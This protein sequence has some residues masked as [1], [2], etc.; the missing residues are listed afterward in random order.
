MLALHSE[1]GPQPI[2]ICYQ[3]FA[4]LEPY[5]LVR[6]ARTTKALRNL[7]LNPPSAPVW[8]KCRDN[9]PGLPH[10]PKGLSEPRYA[11]LMFE[12]ICHVRGYTCLLYLSLLLR[13][14]HLP[15]FHFTVLNKGC[16]ERR[17]S[18]S[19]PVLS[20]MRLRTVGGTPLQNSRTDMSLTLVSK[21]SI[22]LIGR[23][24]TTL[25]Y[26]RLHHRLLSTQTTVRL[27]IRLYA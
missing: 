23:R 25:A 1:L 9:V 15:I 5:D 12:Q 24:T 21:L 10:C 18:S 13:S 6:L 8:R 17:H 11:H 2:R 27:I 16:P 14:S 22:N 19:R 20:E 7:L 4:Q 26:S 3:V